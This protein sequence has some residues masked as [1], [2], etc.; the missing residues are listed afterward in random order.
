MTSSFVV[1]CRRF[2]RF[3]TQ[4]F[5]ITL[6]RRSMASKMLSGSLVETDQELFELIQREKKRQIQGLET[7]A[8]ENFTSVSVLQCLASCLHYKYAEGY[9][10]RRYYG[11]NE[12]FD[13]VE[14]LARARALKAFGL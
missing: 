6:S 9:P 2:S 14:N 8:S 13:E 7:I 11:G 10:G 1:L 5:P 3:N 12:V 4:F